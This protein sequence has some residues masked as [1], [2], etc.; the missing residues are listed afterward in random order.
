[1]ASLGH[2][3]LTSNVSVIC[4]KTF[5]MINCEGKPCLPSEVWKRNLVITLGRPSGSDGIEDII[6]FCIAIRGYKPR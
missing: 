5:D 6:V 1:M 4:W 3:E 2:N